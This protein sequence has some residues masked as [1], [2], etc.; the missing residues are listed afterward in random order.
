EARHLDV[1]QGDVGSVRLHGRHDLVAPPDL[2]HHLEVVLEGQ[3]RGQRR[4]HEVLVVGEQQPDRHAVTE[5]STAA[6]TAAW[7]S[8]PTGTVTRTLLPPGHRGPAVIVPAAAL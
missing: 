2:G 3:Q 1:E 6:G 8:W 5:P 7:S 4:P